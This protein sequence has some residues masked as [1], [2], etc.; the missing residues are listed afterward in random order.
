MH[1][2]QVEIQHIFEQAFSGYNITWRE[3][4]PYVSFLMTGRARRTYLVRFTNEFLECSPLAHV[5]W[6][7][8]RVIKELRAQSR[9]ATATVRLPN[10]LQIIGATEA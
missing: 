4:D 9:S 10:D 5:I 7:C 6:M 3:D 8:Q 2:I 1:T